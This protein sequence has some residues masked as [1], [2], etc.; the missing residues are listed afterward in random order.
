MQILGER[1]YVTVGYD[2][3]H[4][5]DIRNGPLLEH[6]VL[7][8]KVDVIFNL[9]GVLGTQELILDRPTKESLDIITG[10]VLNCLEVGRK[11]DIDIVEVGKPN[12]WLN[13][14]SIAKQASEDF[15]A[16][17]NKELGVNTWIVKWFNI[18]GPGQHYGSPQK[19]APTSIVRALLNKDIPIFGDGEQTADHMYVTDACH[20]CI[21]IYESKKAKGI[22]V[23][24]GSGK[25]MTVNFFVDKVIELTKSKSKK[26]YLRMRQGEEPGAKVKADLTNLKKFTKARPQL[27][28][29]I[30][31]KK[32]INHYARKLNSL[33]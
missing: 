11:H 29:E 24:V 26:K 12:V 21:D 32:T 6:V 19:L 8:R 5:Y 1:K 20:A 13:T 10:G 22:P 15:A 3:A 18:F 28:F 25:E 9:A 4:G 30:A 33:K 31:L 16:M 27:D 7:S 2:I 17:Y 23:E 14:Y